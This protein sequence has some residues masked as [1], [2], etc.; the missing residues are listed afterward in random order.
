MCSYTVQAYSRRWV[1]ILNREMTV[2]IKSNDLLTGE[3]ALPNRAWRLILSAARLAD[4]VD[5]TALG[6]TTLGPPAQTPTCPADDGQYEHIAKA[7]LQ[8]DPIPKPT[9]IATRT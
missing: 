2:R 5:T 1:C 8:P 4:R 7:G 9:P 3:V 6:N